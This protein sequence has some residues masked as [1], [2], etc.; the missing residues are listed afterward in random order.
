[1]F[2]IALSALALAVMAA[3]RYSLRTFDDRSFACMRLLPHHSSAL[4]LGHASSLRARESRPA[5]CVQSSSR[6]RHRRVML[7]TRRTNRLDVDTRWH[8]FPGFRAW[9]A[10]G[11]VRVRVVRRQ[12][13]RRRLI[14]LN[15]T[16]MLSVRFTG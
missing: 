15:P 4:L 6:C 3:V 12:D 2:V 5:V 9:L 11:F 16:C 10:G 8:S 1:M 13:A 7:A 14:P